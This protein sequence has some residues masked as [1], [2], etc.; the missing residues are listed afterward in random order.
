[1]RTTLILIALM[2]AGGFGLHALAER[3]DQAQNTV[4]LGC[5][6]TSPR[7]SR[8]FMPGDIEKEG[9]HMEACF[10]AHGYRPMRNSLDCTPD[11]ASFRVAPFCYVPENWY[12]RQLFWL[13][14]LWSLIA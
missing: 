1:M 12:D 14:H 4:W 13:N 7:P 9:Q 6:H 2:L 8:Q 11:F 10:A 3:Q 5:L